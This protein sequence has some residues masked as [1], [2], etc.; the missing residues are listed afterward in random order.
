MP[1]VALITCAR[2]RPLLAAVTPRSW[3]LRKVRRAATKG[4]VAGVACATLPAGTVVVLFMLGLRGRGTM[5]R[6]ECQEC[7][8]STTEEEG[9]ALALQELR[10]T[11]EG[12]IPPRRVPRF[13]PAD[14][15]GAAM[16]E[17]LSAEAKALID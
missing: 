14:P 8:D 13:E 5:A 9:R 7:Q 15:G 1:S 11:I 16:P 10:S 4:A 17:T 6:P 3:Y 12:Q 2:M